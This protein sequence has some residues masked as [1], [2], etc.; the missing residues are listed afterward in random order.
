M[1][2][3][4]GQT[5][6]GGA[7]FLSV[8]IPAYNEEPR[9]VDTLEKVVEYLGRQSYSWEV[10][11]VDDGSTDSTASL[12][13]AF[14]EDYGGVWL[15][16]VRHGGKGWAVR[17][18]ML[19]STGE[20]RF[21]CDADLSMPVEQIVRFLPPVATDFDIAIG[22]REVSGA[23]R[24]GEPYH[25]HL[26]GRLYNLLVKAIAIP[27]LNDTQ[28][29]FKC[30]R[31]AVAQELFSLQKFPGFSF[32]VEVLFLAR[33]RGA[34]I[35]EVPIDWYYKQDSKVQ[36]LRDSV[37]MSMDILRIRW[38]YLRGKYRTPAVKAKEDAA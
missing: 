33:K 17:H 29:G 32:D 1:S 31:G 14:S 18:G 35:V 6:G 21:L 24:I 15:R 4:Q 34:R 37:A 2:S 19:S 23:R 8:V 10:V 30:F 5:S 20:Y 13:R 12:V 28:C 27:E 36:P 38:R 3:D 25:R 26:M 11:V 22:S 9:I 7:P 16:S